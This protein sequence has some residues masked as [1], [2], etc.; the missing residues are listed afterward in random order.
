LRTDVLRTK[1][2]PVNKKLTVMTTNKLSRAAY[3]PPVEGEISCWDQ[4]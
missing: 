2:T 1:F 3:P 4:A